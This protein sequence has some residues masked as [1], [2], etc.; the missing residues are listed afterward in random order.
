MNGEL[1]PDSWVMEQVGEATFELAYVKYWYADTKIKSVTS[2]IT[3]AA[4]LRR[5]D[6]GVKIGP[7]RRTNCQKTVENHAAYH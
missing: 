5:K 6:T 1:H 4:S 7:Q 2:I 3:F